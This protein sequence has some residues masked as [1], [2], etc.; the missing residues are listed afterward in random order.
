LF[1]VSFFW[2]LGTDSIIASNA[3]YKERYYAILASSFG[4]GYAALSSTTDWNNSHPD[5]N[6]IYLLNSFGM[7]NK[8]DKIGKTIANLLQ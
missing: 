7:V 4:F 3:N 2:R 8:V 6:S 1:A 5:G